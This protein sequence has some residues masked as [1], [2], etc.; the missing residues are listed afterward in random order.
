RRRQW[1]GVGCISNDPE[2]IAQPLD[3]GTGHED[4]AFERVRDLAGCQLPG[5]GREQ[6][7]DRLRAFLTDVHEYERACA[8]GVLRHARLEAGLAEQ[9]RLLVAG[10]AA[11]RYTVDAVDAT[12]DDPEAP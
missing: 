2:S 10:D 4:G 7:F 3:G 11:D 1:L 12:R 9:R 6:A 8:V 5:D